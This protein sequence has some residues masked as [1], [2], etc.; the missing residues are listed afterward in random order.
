MEI[1]RTTRIQVNLPVEIVS[2]FQDAW[3]AACNFI[4]TVSFENNN[5]S[6][7]V[8]LNEITYTDVRQKFGLSAQVAQSAVRFVASTYAGLKTRKAL[9]KRPPFFRNTA[10]ILQ[11]G[12][13]GRNFSIRN[14]LLSITTL[15][16]RE[17]GVTFQGEPKLD[18]YISDW[19]T[20][21]GCLKVIKDKVYLFISFKIEVENIFKPSDSVI[22]VDR[23]INYLAVATDGKRTL[24]AGGG[25]VIHKR[26]EYKQ[27]RAELQ[28][29]KA[30]KNTRSVRR[31]L[32]RLSG[33]QRR[34]MRNENHVLSRRIVN[35]AQQTGSPTIAIEDLSG[36]RN[37]KRLGKK[38]RIEIN[39]WAYG[40]L[41]EMIRYK[42]DTYCFSVVEV[43]PRYTSKGCSNCG[44]VHNSNRQKHSFKCRACG[45]QIHSDLN[46]A[47]NIRLRGI[48]SRQAL[49]GDGLCQPA[50]KHESALAGYG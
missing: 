3:N 39:Q 43:D 8:R 23:G 13:I 30:Q 50:H 42:A 19:N 37:G 1:I 29:R 10:I 16:G 27:R 28:K 14:N 17:K 36:I 11:G 35:F 46:G 26:K 9:V 47:K 41:A 45:Y 7:A 15:E 2:R 18:T 22:G 24:F 5:L 32:K 6:N 49:E 48:I 12:V 33:K 20:G 38:V 44:H 4:S 40:E 25:R 34:F 21:A 31:V